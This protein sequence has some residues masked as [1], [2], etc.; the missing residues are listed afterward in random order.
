MDTD[1]TGGLAQLVV[2]MTTS[3]CAHLNV[4]AALYLKADVERTASL[5]CGFRG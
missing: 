2:P 5:A 1:Y 3:L 4:P